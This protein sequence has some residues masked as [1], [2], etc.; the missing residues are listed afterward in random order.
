M[1]TDQRLGQ[2]A[3]ALSAAGVDALVMGGHAV[4]YYGVD[5]NTVDFDFYAGVGT[6]DEVRNRLNGSQMLAG[7]REGPSWRSGDFVRFELGKLP[8]GREEWLEFWVHNHLLADFRSVRER[9]ERG[10][11][12]GAELQFLSLPDLMRSKETEREGDWRD[13]ELLEEIFDARNLA[14]ASGLESVTKLIS[15]LR[16]RRGFERAK[17][18][19]VFDDRAVV[20][21]AAASCQHP[22]S[23]AFVVPLMDGIT[24]APALRCAIDKTL[25]EPLR[26]ASFGEPRHLMLVELV[27]RAY[28]RWAMEIDRQ[29]KQQRLTSKST[30]S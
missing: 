3:G 13:I 28:K 21:A 14:A 23:Y 20:Q 27:R 15:Q 10:T 18:Q 8:D 16:S 1:T 24:P 4:R 6:T 11:Y 26:I 12:G 2:I 5:R 22:V 9:G 7:L 29:D 25:I 30:Q 17:V 19:G